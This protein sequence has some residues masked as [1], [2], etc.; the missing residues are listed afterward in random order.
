MDEDEELYHL[1]NEEDDLY[2]GDNDNED[3]TSSPQNNNVGCIYLIV[4]AALL[5]GLFFLIY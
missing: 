1:M 5:L 3:K 4:L 2:M